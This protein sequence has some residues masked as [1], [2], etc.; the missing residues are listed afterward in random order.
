MYTNLFLLVKMC[1]HVLY[2]YT[3]A[4][5]RGP[6]QG[7]PSRLGF[8]MFMNFLRIKFTSTF[9]DSRSKLPVNN[10]FSAK[11]AMN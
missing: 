6:P 1:K 2:K 3:G 7:G 8:N 10:S 11:K 5:A 9:S 4:Q